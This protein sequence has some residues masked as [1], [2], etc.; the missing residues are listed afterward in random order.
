VK[1]EVRCPSCH[2]G[3]LVEERSVEDGLVCPGCSA[4]IPSRRPRPAIAEPEPASVSLSAVGAEP[5]T[6]RPEPSGDGGALGGAV[7][8]P[9]CKLHF[10]PR[11]DRELEP[12]ERRT[13]LVVE[14]MEY[15]RQVARHALEAKYDVQTARSTAEGIALLAQ[16]PVDLV[17]LDLTLEGK[18]EGRELLTH[19][20]RKGCPVIVYTARD[21]S[22]IYG[23]SWEELKRLGARD[24]VIKGMNVGESLARKADEILGVAEQ[25]D[26]S[27]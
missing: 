7:V 1:I 6:P 4:E 10:T 2:R 11:D 17:V 22:E 15:F 13:V 18:D 20:A 9:R 19:A 8:C 14:D 26:V 12:E 16:L 24:I 3:M 25:H 5:A 23:E 27:L 21:E